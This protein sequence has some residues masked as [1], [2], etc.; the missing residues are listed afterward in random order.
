MAARQK[1][2]PISAQTYSWNLSSRGLVCFKDPASFQTVEKLWEAQEFTSFH[3]ARLAKATTQINAILSRVDKN[4]KDP[5]RSLSFIQFQNRLLLCW[6]KYGA[7]GP[8]DDDGAIG[9][10]L[11]LR[12]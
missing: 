9:T 2:L 11:R 1:A 12:K 6:A 7:I 4:N 8:S 10:A 5:E 3:D